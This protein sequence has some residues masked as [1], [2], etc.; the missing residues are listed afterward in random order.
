LTV[1]DNLFAQHVGQVGADG[2]PS[3]EFGEKEYFRKT[4]AFDDEERLARIPCLNDVE[5]AENIPPFS[6][7]RYRCLVQDVFEPELYAGILR[8]VDATGA[9]GTPPRFVTTKYREC[10]G[11]PKPGRALQELDGHASLLQ[12]GACYCVPLPGE[13]SWARSAAAEWTHAGGGSIPTTAGPA[14]MAAGNSK[15]RRDE[16]VSMEPTEEVASPQKPRVAVP[17]APQALCQPCNAGISAAG[18]S[19]GQAGLISAE[20]FGL[21]FPL[22]SEESRGRGASTACIVK[23]YDSDAQEGSSPMRLCATIE[24]IGVLCVNPDIAQLPDAQTGRMEDDWRDARSPS[25]SLVP[26]LHALA[27]RPLSFYHPLLPFSTAFLTE[28]RLASAFQRQFSMPNS[29]LA[30]RNAAV[31]E[32]AKHV[33]ADALAAEYI[34]MLLVAR[35]F[36]KHGETSV[37]SWSLNLA[38]WPSSLNATTLADA[39]GELV[40]RAALLEVTNST[41]NTKAWKPR[42]DFVANRLVAGQLQQ[43]AGTLLIF[44][45]SKMVEGELTAEGVKAYQ[46]IKLLVTENKLACDYQFDVNIPLEVSS[47]LL[48]ERRSLVK[49]AD[50][51][52]PL[53]PQPVS[54]GAVAP[55]ALHAARWLVALVTRSP[56]SL[57]ISEDAQKVFADDFAMVRQAY[58]VGPELAS[59]WMAIARARCLTF[60]EQA[61]SVE[62]WREVMELEKVRL[63]RC[64]EDSLLEA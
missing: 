35:S 23:F 48:S 44:D 62:R 9:G 7:V 34:L 39:V 15:R 52:V 8:E 50:I 22:P 20:D 47:I 28:E 32:L 45:E 41:L 14:T 30:A 25:T 53:R 3:L 10:S 59:T 37:G 60:G 27:V 43:A 49:E 29:I 1:I 64:R 58:K 13:R 11:E 2:V 19:G 26:R 56:R 21:N 42:K 38:G 51:L 46:A 4:L 54:N 33:G 16:D 12:R 63:C 24:V 31:E 5:L 40:P 55:D 18:R 36:R 17:Q 57:I 6:L 61:L